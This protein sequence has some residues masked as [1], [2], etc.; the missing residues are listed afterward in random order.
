MHGA[1][2]RKFRGGT[3]E[4]HV[5]TT[6][7]VYVHVNLTSFNC[8]SSPGP[9]VNINYYRYYGDERARA[10]AVRNRRLSNAKIATPDAPV[11][12]RD[13]SRFHHQRLSVNGSG[14]LPLVLL[15]MERRALGTE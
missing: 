10:C 13:L 15:L 14:I 1:W 5:V 8:R 6:S 4:R 7:T 12:L 2:L 3:V 11:G 9:R